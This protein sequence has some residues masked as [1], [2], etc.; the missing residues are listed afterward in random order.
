[1][2][3]YEY[4]REDG[5]VFECIQ[6]IKDDPLTECPETGQKVKRLI[7]GGSGTIIQGWSPD[8]ERKKKEW[9][10]KNPGGTTLPEYQKQ[11]DENT[12]KAREMKENA[13]PN[14]TEL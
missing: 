12:Q 3:T 7:S 11:I 8:K 9:I 5:T 1:M 13:K 4:K 10:E 6:S 2:P 14:I